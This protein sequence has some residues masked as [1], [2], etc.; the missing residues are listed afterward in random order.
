MHM[1]QE[2]RQWY[3][4]DNYETDSALAETP[5]G[6]FNAD[7]IEFESFMFDGGQGIGVDLSKS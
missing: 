5:T 4:N 7:D 6:R 1:A 2:S 3:Q